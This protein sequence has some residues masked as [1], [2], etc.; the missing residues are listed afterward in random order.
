[1]HKRLA[2]IAIAAAVLIGNGRCLAQ[3][4]CDA[5]SHQFSWSRIAAPAVLIGAGTFG[6]CSGWYSQNVNLP[7]K[8]YMAG[9]RQGNYLHADDYIQYVPVAASLLLSL[10]PKYRSGWQDRVVLAA[11][12]AAV[13]AALVNGLKYTVCELRPDGSRANSFPSGHTATAFMGAELVRLEYGG[14]WGAAAYT[15]AAATGFLRMY[16]ERHWSSD[17]LAGAGFGILSARL[18][19]WLLPW[20]RRQLGKLSIM[21]YFAA[22]PRTTTACSGFALCYNF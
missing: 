20:E 4:A 7:V 3:G 6:L 13:S 5:D 12:G 2:C 14:W 15:I 8:D 1:M 10:A 9:L 21:P 11:T 18:A 17:V 19:W 22:V 16:N